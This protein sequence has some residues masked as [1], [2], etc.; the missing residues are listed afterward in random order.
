MCAC[1]SWP[2]SLIFYLIPN[3]Q[4]ERDSDSGSDSVRTRVFPFLSPFVCK[5]LFLLQTPIVFI[6][7]RFDLMASRLALCALLSLLSSVAVRAQP[8]Y[9]TTNATILATCVPLPSTVAFCKGVFNQW[10]TPYLVSAGLD[11]VKADNKTYNS[12]QAALAIW[13][14]SPNMYD[15]G[16]QVPGQTMCNDCL[17]VQLLYWCGINFPRCVP[18]V[19]QAAPICK[20]L[21]EDQSRRCVLLSVHAFHLFFL[22]QTEELIRARL[23]QVWYCGGLFRQ[24]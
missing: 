2:C 4:F 22:R 24:P 8:S 1:A 9:T 21:C 20:Y 17:A 15:C 10:P 5:L 14:V 3:S 6:S 19:T 7:P 23:M 11:T 13:Q 12:Y 18:G 16:G